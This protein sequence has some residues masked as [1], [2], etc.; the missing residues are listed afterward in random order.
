VEKLSL[1]PCMV[2]C[3]KILTRLGKLARDKRCSL[4]G[5]K[6][7]NID[8]RLFGAMMPASAGEKSDD[9]DDDEAEDE[10]RLEIVILAVE[11]KWFED[12]KGSSALG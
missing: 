12:K 4:L 7:Y 3:Q 8:T 9:D 5:E 10:F 2:P 1:V 11:D 6:K